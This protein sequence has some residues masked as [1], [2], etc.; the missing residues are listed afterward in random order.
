MLKC[1]EKENVKNTTAKPT[2]TKRT[3]TE[4]YKD[5]CSLHSSSFAELVKCYK[6]SVNIT[7][8]RP[9]TKNRTI[10]E[11]YREPCNPN[12]PFFELLECYNREE[13]SR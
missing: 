3:T 4:R 8:L 13:G 2:T 9:I 1:Y 11:R 10:T 6:G 7:T 12:L 5:P